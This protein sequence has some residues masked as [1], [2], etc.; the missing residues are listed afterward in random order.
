MRVFSTRSQ[1]AG[2]GPDDSEFAHLANLLGP[3][4]TIPPI[5]SSGIADTFRAVRTAII[6]AR[7]G[8]L[9]TIGTFG[10]RDEAEIVQG[11]LASAGIDASIRADD[12][13]GAYPFVLS[14]GAQV[15]VD[16][17]DAAAASEM[18]ANRTD[19]T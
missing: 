11:L 7:V 19:E 2:A 1:A 14:G 13:G 17:S 5:T 6:S 16:E 18:L 12:A 15:L 9:I 10:T 8:R 3:R 4:R